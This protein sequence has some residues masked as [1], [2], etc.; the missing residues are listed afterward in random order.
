M[1]NKP[2]LG[3]LVGKAISHVWLGDYAAL[4]LELGVLSPGRLRHDGS[5]GN[6]VGEATVYA[7]F[8]WKIESENG[9]LFA[10]QDRPI[11][12]QMLADRLRDAIVVSIDLTSRG[13]Q[14]KIE[15]LT[16]DTLTTQTSDTADPAWSVSFNSPKLG[17][18]CMQNG[19]LYHDTSAS[20]FA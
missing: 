1:S 8:G 13:N 11:Y 17:H 15:L 4:Y 3:L 16:A 10:S 5:I 6:A 14:L 9:L 7:G 20:A 18:L 2:S 12:Y 19:A